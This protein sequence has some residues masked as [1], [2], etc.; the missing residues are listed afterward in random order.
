MRTG[1]RQATGWAVLLAMAGGTAVLAQANRKWIDPPAELGTTAPEPNQ[2][3]KGQESGSPQDGQ[4]GP[5]SGP[6]PARTPP[7]ARMA[8]PDRALPDEPRSSARSAA[9]ADAPAA[10]ERA[11]PPPVRSA[12]PP[13]PAAAPPEAGPPVVGER[14]HRPPGRV[15]SREEAARDLLND[16][17]DL[18]SAPNPLT[19]AGSTEFYAPHVIF[20]GRSMSVRALL[21]EKRRFVQRWPERRY[22]ARP[23]TVGIACGPGGETCTVRSV[24]DFLAVDPERGRRS[25]G[26]ATLEL[27]IGF[28]DE[29]R[30]VIVA[31]N[32]LV[33]GRGRPVADNR[34]GDTDDVP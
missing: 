5:P 21:E 4:V 1:L 12:Q 2:P 32:S 20:H 30:P 22:R 34:F 18:W 24:F 23:D 19:L 27:V 15:S 7:T 6:E 9:P 31:E 8:Q 25:Q 33:H 13:R 17:L 29:D 28:G 14:P 16:Y 26:I 3:P 11:P 10:T